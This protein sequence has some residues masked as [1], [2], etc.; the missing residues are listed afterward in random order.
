[1][2]TIDLA[3]ELELM[4]M[5]SEEGG[6][7]LA[8]SDFDLPLQ[9]IVEPVLANFVDFRGISNPKR[10]AELE[11]AIS[12]CAFLEYSCLEESLYPTL[13]HVDGDCAQTSAVSEFYSEDDEDEGV[14]HGYHLI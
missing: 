13:M 6:L 14:R 1:M 5:P 12:A 8:S 10:W 7:E 11:C 3:L 2:N 4:M 9:Q